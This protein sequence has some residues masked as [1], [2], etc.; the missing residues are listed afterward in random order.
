MTETSKN[1]HYITNLL[2]EFFR[3]LRDEKRLE[4]AAKDFKILEDN[5]TYLYE[6]LAGYQDDYNLEDGTIFK[7]PGT[8]AN[9]GV[10]RTEDKMV[11]ITCISADLYASEKFHFSEI[12]CILDHILGIV[13]NGSQEFYDLLDENNATN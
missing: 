6:I 1:K 11:M 13:F 5:E 4:E 9:I 7:L 8:D 12:S 3:T 2:V 10:C